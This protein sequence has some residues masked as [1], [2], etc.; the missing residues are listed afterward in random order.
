MVVS[1]WMM[2]QELSIAVGWSGEGSCPSHLV[3][4]EWWP[5]P[6]GE[7]RAWC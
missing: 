2:L 6:R 1:S 5:C 3:L 4:Q 7:D